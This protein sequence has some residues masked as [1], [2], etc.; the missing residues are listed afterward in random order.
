MI[1]PRISVVTPN[2]NGA[3]YL[4]ETILSVLNQGYDNLEYI[5]IDGGSTDGSIDIIKKY[6][7][8]LAYWVSEP[9]AGL[10]HAIQK[11]FEKS[12]GDIMAWI[13]SDDMYHRGAFDIV[14]DLFSHF[15]SIKWV[16]GIPSTFDEK[17]RTIMVNDYRQ[18]CKAHYHSGNFEWIQQE[19]IF[20]HRDLWKKAGATL[21]TSLKYAA[22]F[23]LWMRFF[24]Y[25]ELFTLQAL[26]GGFRVRKSNQISMD[27][28]DAYV[29][30][31]KTTIKKELELLPADYVG[32]I[33]AM[34]AFE[35]R[36][37]AINIKLLRSIYFRRNYKKILSYRKDLYRYPPRI[38]F[39]R[40]TQ[41]FYF[42]KTS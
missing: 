28:R 18:W 4:E 39:D 15:P 23:E 20:W 17:G 6:E 33:E 1:N 42:Q 38:E 22:D 12:T 36:L 41:Q 31:V 3:S 9:D 24:R 8:R 13:N 2:F 14:A 30:E 16:Q 26:L 27:H 29:Q 37:K 34:N 40:L 32:K 11:G 21:N 25:E 7:S 5:I 10:Y 35:N 19:S